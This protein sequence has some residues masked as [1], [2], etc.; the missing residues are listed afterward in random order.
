[1]PEHHLVTDGTNIS[2]GQCINVSVYLIHTLKAEELRAVTP[3]PDRDPCHY[4]PVKV[5]KRAGGKKTDAAV[6]M[7]SIDTPS[8]EAVK[9]TTPLVE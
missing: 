4:Q 6:Q 2:E 1:M 7:S 8:R 9:V 3:S 5:D